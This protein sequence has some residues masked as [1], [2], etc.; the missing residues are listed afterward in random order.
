MHSTTLRAALTAAVL[1]AIAL[2]AHAQAPA[3]WN[4]GTF[5]AA[6]GGCVF[7]GGSTSLGNSAN[8]RVNG[9]ATTSLVVRAF[10]L[11]GTSGSS[12]VSAGA[13]RSHGTSGLGVCHD[14]E[15]CT[16]PNHAVDNIAGRAD[17]LLLDFLAPARLDGL[18]IGWIDNSRDS[19]LQV[20]RWTGNGNPLATLV[21]ASATQMLAG[22][23]WSVVS[24][25]SNAGLGAESFSS[26]Q[27]TS[28]YWIVSAYNQAFQ[29]QNW[30]NGD[31]AFKLS[32]VSASVVPEPSTYALLATGLAAL[33]VVSRRRRRA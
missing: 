22:S 6:T 24:S 9:S 2:P 3:T 17:F 8:C 1:G 5:G 25:R 20:L 10:S 32:A 26:N 29:N 30:S 12:T 19:D 23:G 4:L 28:R 33:G 16:A 18:S 21:G 31:D 27:L 13:V 7:V 11:S 14:G 15:S